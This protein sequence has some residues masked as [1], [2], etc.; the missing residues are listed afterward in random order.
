MTRIHVSLNALEELLDQMA[1]FDHALEL[2]L[3]RAEA[4]AR[5]LAATWSGAASSSY[6]TAH[7]SCERDLAELRSAMRRLRGNVATA[8]ANYGSAVAA[9]ARMW[10]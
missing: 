10:R 1:S 2:R 4:I 5:S 9:N 8:H 6:A 3:A 7:A